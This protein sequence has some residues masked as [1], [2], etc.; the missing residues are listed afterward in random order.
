MADNEIESNSE[1]EIEIDDYRIWKKNTKLFY[2]VLISHRLSWPSISVD[3]LGYKG[4]EKSLGYRTHRLVYGTHTSSQEPEQLIIDTI[5]IPLDEIT[6]EQTESISKKDSILK[7][8]VS[9]AHQGEPNKIRPNLLNEFILA[10]KSSNGKVYIYNYLNV[11]KGCGKGLEKVLTGHRGEGYGLCW[12]FI[13]LLASGSYD[14]SVCV[15]DCKSN[16]TEPVYKHTYHSDIVED[17]AWTTENIMVSVGDDKKII[18]ADMRTPIKS[19]E[20]V[21]HQGNINSIDVN[22]H[23]SELILT[24]SSD[25]FISIWDTRK[26][27]EHL[28]SFNTSNE[29]YLAKWAPFACNLFASCGSDNKVSIRNLSKQDPLCFVHEGHFSRINEF[30]WNPNENLN[31]AS[32]DEDN[33]LQVWSMHP[34]YLN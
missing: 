28:A 24:G 26:P 29:V 20:I 6:P 10:S 32:V 12:N 7:T 27:G 25:G 13:D 16:A 23:F 2:S 33:C 21:G 31:I 30:S 5:K 19:I 8:M 1:Y 9:M 34:E 4:D 22:K 11:A 14:R 3:W 17:I 15:W 18:F